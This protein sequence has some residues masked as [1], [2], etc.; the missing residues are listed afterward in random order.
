MKS[1]TIFF[2]GKPGCGKGTQTRLLAERSGWPVF[3]SGELFREIAK[4][5]T[6]VGRKVKI[7]NDAGL[8]APHWFAMYLYLKS[9]FSVTEDMGVIFD[10]FNRKIPEAELVIDS[11]KWLNR[12]FIVLNIHISDDEVRRRLLGRKEIEGR[13]DDSAA[14]E[15]LKEYYAH[16]EPSMEVFRATGRLFDLQGEQSRENIA[17]DILKVLETQ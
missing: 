14:E 15:R 1:H 3:A 8:L 2:I 7:E 6:P 4:L 13:E 10:G 16:T 9:L 11:L 12:S 17:K 5:D